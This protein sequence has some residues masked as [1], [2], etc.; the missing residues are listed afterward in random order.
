MFKF[1]DKISPLKILIINFFLVIALGL[2][3]YLTGNEWSFHVFYFIPI[4]L[5]SWYLGKRI[6]YSFVFLCIVVWFCARVLA[7]SSYSSVYIFIWN[8]GTRLGVFIIISSLLSSLRINTEIAHKNNLNRQKQ[9]IV[10]DTAQRIIGI[11]AEYISVKNSEILNWVNSKN[12][13]RQKAP[14][15]VA[16]ASQSI[17]NCLRTLT[18]VFYGDLFNSDKEIEDDYIKHLEKKLAKFGKPCRNKK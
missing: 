3:D 14:S 10:M 12:E 5:V 6:A 9:R 17:G 18:E 15:V 2:L 13:T 8:M 4:S 7:G 11:I 1:L 16:S